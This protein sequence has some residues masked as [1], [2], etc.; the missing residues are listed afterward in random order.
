MN[1]SM[2]IG[3]KMTPLVKK[4][5]ILLSGIWFFSL[6]SINWL[7]WE[8]TG[9]LFK[10]TLLHPA[11]DDPNSI[12][13]GEVWQLA[14]YMFLHDLQSPMHLF[15]NGLMLWFFAPLFETRWGG[16][17]L[18]TFLLYCGIG[19]ALFTVVAAWISPDYFGAPV[20]GASG[21]ILG[22]IAAF[23]LVYPDQPIY[24][25]FILKIEGRYLI[26]ITLGID[27]LLF[28]TQPGS[29]AFATHVGG[30]LSGYL[31]I[32]GSWRPKV[33]RDKVR[34]AKLRAKRRHL[35]VVDSKEKW[36]N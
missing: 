24:L 16:K 33:M 31:L 23:A 14:T 15:F 6:I 35:K 18:A 13:G 10:H 27:T 17:A 25:W 21:A 2:R 36:I 30:L 19:A 12:L 28:L 32:T 9:S 8:W 22:L 11:S 5:L 34:L 29:F 26:P 3:P 20:L 7:G 1:Q 4:L